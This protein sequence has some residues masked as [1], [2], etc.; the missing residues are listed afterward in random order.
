MTARFK[1]NPVLVFV[2]STSARAALLALTTHDSRLCN[3]PPPQVVVTECADSS[4][5]LIL[6]FWIRDESLEKAMKCEYLEKAKKALDAAGIDIP[7]PHMQLLL[8][9]TDAVRVLA[10]RAD[11]AA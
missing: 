7:F 5:N 11:R 4:V 6:R 2:F 9:S 3:D 1:S 10:G 8:E